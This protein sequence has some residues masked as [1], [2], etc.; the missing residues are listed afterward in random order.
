M[1][2]LDINNW[3]TSYQDQDSFIYSTFPNSTYNDI[4]SG[5]NRLP[6]VELYTKQYH[7]EVDTTAFIT[8]Y[9]MLEHPLLHKALEYY[10]KFTSGAYNNKY[11]EYG[12]HICL[13]NGA[14]S[15]IAS[16]FE[17]MHGTEK[18][19]AII[20]LGYHYFLFAVL[21]RHYGFSYTTLVCNS[22]NFNLPILSQIE[23]AFN[24]I[25]GRYVFLTVPSN[26]SGEIYTKT[27]MMQLIRLVLKYDKILVIDK[28]LW[29][30]VTFQ[31]HKDYYSISKLLIEENAVSNTIIIHSFSKI[32]GIPGVR[33]G[34]I[35]A[36]ENLVKFTKYY[37]E[38]LYCM[39]NMTHILSL[40]IDLFFQ[41][42]LL[43]HEIDINVLIKRFRHIILE[44]MVKKETQQI[45]F[46]FLKSYE[47]ELTSYHNILLSNNLQMKNNFCKTKQI[48]STNE[49]VNFTDMKTGFNFCMVYSNPSELQERKYIADI[50]EKLR[51]RIYTQFN[52]CANMPRRSIWFRISCAN[53][54]DKNYFEKMQQLEKILR[55]N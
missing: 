15:A 31:Y 40:A 10:E 13:T 45:L 12:N 16:L 46:D 33:F 2:L 44:S 35:L 18:E 50:A 39:S 52:F 53:D 14:T 4:S 5:I 6:I 1:K 34:Y 28:C 27:E 42:I 17:Y 8:Q 32:R 41:T 21:A 26:P 51:S 24:N 22:E 7:K 25:K 23:T 29:D 54:N 36:N 20:L 47:G 9:E 19:R 11:L 38:K 49:F 3:Y 43:C 55:P 48:F 30:D 37:L